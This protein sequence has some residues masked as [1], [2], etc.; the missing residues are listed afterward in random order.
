MAFLQYHQPEHLT[1]AQFYLNTLQIQRL[2]FYSITQN[3]Y[4]TLYVTFLHTSLHYFPPAHPFF[5]SKTLI[6]PTSRPIFFHILP[7]LYPSPSFTIP[8][9]FNLCPDFTFHHSHTL[10][11]NILTNLLMKTQIRTNMK[12]SSKKDLERNTVRVIQ[13]QIAHLALPVF[14]SFIPI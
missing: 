14:L 9:V 7:N 1:H 3:H 10:C 12:N 2:I 11:R 13:I 5:L 8:L 4:R 6:T